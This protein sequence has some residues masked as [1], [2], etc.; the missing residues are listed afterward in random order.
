[1]LTGGNDPARTDGGTVNKED[2][3]F[4]GMEAFSED[5]LEEAI[6]HLESA[7]EL[8]P[9][10]GDALHAL[11]MSWYHLGDL[12][13]AVLYGER[14]RQAEP[15]NI[16]AYTSLSMFYNAKGFIEKAEIMGAEAARL[17]GEQG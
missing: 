3:Y 4:K 13:Q 9:T 5:R 10:Y 17:A 2:L 1:M 7:L 15:D 14:L 8:D 12:D 11:A 16:H 6:R